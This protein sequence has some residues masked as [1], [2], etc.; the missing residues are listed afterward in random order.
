MST[1]E[2]GDNLPDNLLNVRDVAPGKKFAVIDVITGDVV[3]TGV[4][5][6]CAKYD[7]IEDGWP[8][9]WRVEGIVDGQE[10]VK[11]LAPYDMGLTCSRQGEWATRFTVER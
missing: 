11:T 1:Y 3:E 10:E 8:T 2:R 5:T 4:F 7:D 9:C 6:S